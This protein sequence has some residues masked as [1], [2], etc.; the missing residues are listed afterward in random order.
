MNLVDEAAY[1]AWKAKNAQPDPD[2]PDQ[3]YARMGVD[4]GLACFDRAERV[5]NLVEARL[6]QGTPF[7]EAC[8]Q[9]DRQ[10]GRDAEAEG[11]RDAGLTG[12]QAGCMAAILAKHWVHGEAFRRW[13]NLDQQLGTEGEQANARGT[14]LNPALLNV[15]RRDG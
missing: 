12:F 7:D 1:A 14:V 11:A 6:A 9:A 3:E 8:A 13:W 5:A 15:G 10:A 2:E 4:Y